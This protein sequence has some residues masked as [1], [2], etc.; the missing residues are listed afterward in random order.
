M[1]VFVRTI[2]AKGLV[3]GDEQGEADQ[4]P[5]S[6][7]ADLSDLRSKLENL[8]FSAYRLISS[9]EEQ[10]SLMKRDVIH[11]PNGQSLAFRPV[12]MEGR[13]VGL[14]LSWRDNSG[15]DILD[16]RIHFDTDESVLTGTDATNDSGLILAIKAVPVT[17]DGK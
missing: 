9:R 12:Y 4:T 14:W 16:T 7:D 10:I 1:K 8:P 11:L 5:P 3:E 17:R 6:I 13:R 15:A 2:E